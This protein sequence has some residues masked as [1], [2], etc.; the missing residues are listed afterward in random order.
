M[1]F[2]DRAITF[3]HPPVLPPLITIMSRLRFK[4]LRLLIALD[5]IKSLHKA[6][7]SVSITQ[8]GESPLL[9]LTLF[10]EIDFSIR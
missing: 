8:P 1:T 9:F 6:V 7:E 5:D 3:S 10:D 2:A 4:Q